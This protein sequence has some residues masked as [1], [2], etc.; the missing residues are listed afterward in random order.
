MDLPDRIA[1]LESL[2]VKTLF[3][4]FLEQGNEFSM[5]DGVPHVVKR[6]MTVGFVEEHLALPTGEAEVVHAALLAEGWLEPES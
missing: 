4:K 2:R 1:G 6:R 3:Q 5:K